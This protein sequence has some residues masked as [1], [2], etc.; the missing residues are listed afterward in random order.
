M[1]HD[2]SLKSSPRCLALLRLTLWALAP[3]GLAELGKYQLILD[4]QL[5]GL[6]HAAPSTSEA[7]APAPASAT[8]AAD[9]RMTMM[10]RDVD[11]QKVR[12]GLQHLRDHSALLLVEGEDSHPEFRLE[13]ADFA[14]G[15]AE[16]RYQGAA[17]RFELQ[18]GPTLQPADP[19]GRARGAPTAT[20]VE[21]TTSRSTAAPGFVRTR[22]ESPVAGQT[23][24][25]PPS[26][27]PPPDS[28]SS[29]PPPV[30]EPEPGESGET[31][32]RAIP[33]LMQRPMSREEAVRQGLT[34][35]PT[36]EMP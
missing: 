6:A 35:P 32:P 24:F 2:L 33:R 25:L 1:K 10:T 20:R 4:K 5:L 9:Y 14:V 30:E 27:P 3:R 18:D 7:V 31:P 34:T 13:S 19:R 22:S 26:L 12:V 8:W 23:R 16:I 15:V 28:A 29:P 17:A 21:V 36:L 11:H